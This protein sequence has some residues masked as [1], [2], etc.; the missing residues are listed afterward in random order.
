[1][2]LRLLWL[3]SLALVLLGLYAVPAK[4]GCSID[5]HGGCSAQSGLASAHGGSSIDPNGS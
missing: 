2:T 1:M 5:P 4:N 3:G